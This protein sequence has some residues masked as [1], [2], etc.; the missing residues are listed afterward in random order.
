MILAQELNAV[1]TVNSDQVSQTNQ[2]IFRTLERSLSDFVN[3][4]RWT[5]RN[6]TPQERLQCRFFITVTKY[7][8]GFFEANLQIQSARPVYNTTY[9]S[10]VFNYKDNQFNFDYIEFQPLA[11]NE[12]VFNSNL[13]GVIAYYVNIMLG[14]DAD[15][16]ALESGTP[17]YQRAQALVTQAQGSGYPGWGQSTSDGRSRF[18][19]A[20]N[21]LSNTFREYRSA[22]Y[23]YHRMGLDA[24][25]SDPVT[26]KQEIIASI[27]PFE[28]LN[29]RRP[30]A[31]VLQAFF[32]AKSEEIQNIFSDGPQVALDKLKRT[33][34]IV[35]PFYAAT[36]NRI[37][38]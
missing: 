34:S 37:R 32:D 36:W 35:A 6:Y 1:V 5:S 30:N 12:S 7:E 14:L 13:V 4:T 28:G 24:M 19:L 11:F 16:F 8:A 27:L 21:L 33:L 29:Q 26:A 25:T 18:Q 9:E 10:P 31:L 2:Q 20:D 22:L 15:T 23:Q 3:R 17:Y 38:N